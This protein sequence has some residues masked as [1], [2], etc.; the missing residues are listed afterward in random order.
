V[1]AFNRDFGV[2]ELNQASGIRESC[3]GIVGQRHERASESQT[4]GTRVGQAEMR[5][6]DE[7]SRFIGEGAWWE[8]GHG[9]S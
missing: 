1:P 3:R 9:T 4:A 7:L 5:R 2:S 6:E 8:A